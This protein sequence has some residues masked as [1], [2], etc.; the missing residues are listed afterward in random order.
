MAQPS[1]F[2]AGKIASSNF[3]LC[4]SASIVTSQALVLLSLSYLIT[5]YYTDYPKYQFSSVNQ[6]CLTLCDPM[7]C[8]TPGLPVHHQL[9]E[10]TQAHVHWVGDAIQPSHP[11][12]SPKIIQNNLFISVQIPFSQVR[13]HVH[14][15]Q[16]L[17]CGRLWKA[18]IHPTIPSMVP[19]KN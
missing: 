13:W 12:S 1:I 19:R 17:G 2:K 16:G 6:S 7:Y 9:P 18:I 11:L 15:F 5:Y 14:R 10:F 8:S 3:S 4:P